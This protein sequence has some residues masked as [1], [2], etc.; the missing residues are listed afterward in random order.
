MSSV[1]EFIKDVRLPEMVKVRQ[2]FDKKCIVDI[3][4]ENSPGPCR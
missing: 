1:K 2:I 4:A 3:P